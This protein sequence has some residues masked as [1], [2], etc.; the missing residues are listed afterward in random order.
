ML[1]IWQFG[2]KVKRRLVMRDFKKLKVWSDSHQIVLQ[3]YK[4]S[5]QFPKE[6]LFGMTSQIRRSAASVPYNIAEGCGRSSEKELRRFC[7][8]AMGSASELEY[9]TF[10]AH[11]LQYL[12]QAE[13]KILADEIVLFK[14]RLNAFIQKLR[15]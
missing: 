12:K 14:K 5:K 1:A 7:D 6:E 4:L 9:Q 15:E 8:I 11:E 3:I 2:F 10:L 13:Y